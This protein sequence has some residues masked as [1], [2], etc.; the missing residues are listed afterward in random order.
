MGDLEAQNRMK[1]NNLLNQLN[2]YN[3][4]NCLCRNLSVCKIIR[5]RE[6]K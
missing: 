2:T 1:K 3:I 4:Y 6:F 5:T